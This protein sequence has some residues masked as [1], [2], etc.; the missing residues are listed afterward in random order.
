MALDEGE[1]VVGVGG[2]VHVERVGGHV[3][4]AHVGLEVV[5]G[6]HLGR[7]AAAVG[8]EVEDGD[9]GGRGGQPVR[10]DHEAVDGA[11]AGAAV[12]AGVVIVA[13]SVMT[14]D[15]PDRGSSVTDRS[16]PV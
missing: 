5:F 2:V 15:R 9:G 6:E 8:V 1:D 10:R 13:V 16:V 4:V 7:A 12:G 3:V 14:R 11:V